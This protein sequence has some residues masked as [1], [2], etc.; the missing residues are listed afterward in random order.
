MIPGALHVPQENV[1]EWAD[2]PKAFSKRIVLYC[3]RGI[4]SLELAAK[5]QERGLNAR[6]LQDGYNG[7][8]LF[9]MKKEKELEA[10]DDGEGDSSFPPA[11]RQIED[12]IRR[13]IPQGSVF[14][15]CKSR[16]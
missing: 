4:F 12:S 9:S 14:P 15:F 7:W 1:P 2:T 3:S 10:S 6:S 5:L 13:Q 11:T 16:L 8:L